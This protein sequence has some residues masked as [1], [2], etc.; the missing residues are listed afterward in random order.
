[1]SAA[2]ELPA[3]T[4]IGRRD[5]RSNNSWMH[6]SE[7]LVKGRERCTLLMHPAD[8]QARALADGQRVALRSRAG[9]VVV[10]LEVTGAMRPGVV[11]LPHGW[12]HGRDGVL[13][14]VA[15]EHPGQSFNDV[16]DE[17]QVDPLSGTAVLNGIPVEVGPA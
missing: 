1:A 6:N 13:L 7:R 12:G 15:R 8:A 16:A 3:L 10:P 11:C 4:L 17:L 14:R 9:S 2:R 5:L